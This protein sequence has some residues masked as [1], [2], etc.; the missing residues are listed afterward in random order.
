MTGGNAFYVTELLR[1][2]STS[3]SLT[4]QDAVL[5]RVDRLSSQDRALLEAV[6]IFPRHA[7]IVWAMVLSGLPNEA[8]IR[9]CVASGLLTTDGSHLAFRHEIARQAVET[10]LTPLLRKTLNTKLLALLQAAPAIPV[11]RLL[12]HARQCNDVAAIAAL[13]PAAGREAAAAGAHLQ[14]AEYFEVALS[15]TDTGDAEHLA[16]LLEDVALEHSEN[17]AFRL[18]IKRLEQA[19]ALRLT[20]NQQLRAGEVMQ[21]MSLLHSEAGQFTLAETVGDSAISLLSGTQS[22][23]LAMA[24]AARAKLA[25]NERD[26]ALADEL[27]QAAVALAR[28]VDRVDVLSHALNTLGMNHWGTDNGRGL[29]DQS[30]QLALEHRFPDHII[31]AYSNRATIEME[32]LRYPE[33]LMDFDQAIANAQKYERTYNLPWDRARRLELLLRMGR[34]DEAASGCAGLFPEMSDQTVTWAIARLVRA[35]L[36]TRR[37][38][39]DANSDIAGIVEYLTYD[40][41]WLH[42]NIFANLMAERAW[43]GLEDVQEA[44]KWMD[45]VRSISKTELQTQQTLTWQRLLEPERAI[46]IPDGTHPAYRLALEGNWRAAALAWQAIGDPYAQALALLEGD[47]EAVQQSLAILDQLGAI[48]VASHVRKRFRVDEAMSGSRG[49]RA[50]TR[51][52]PVGLTRRQMQVLELLNTGKS[53]A[54][55]AERLF[56]S[57]KTVDHHVSAI[58]AKLDVASRSEAA[59]MARNAGWLS[60]SS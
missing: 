33:A 36:A 6:S 23:E 14:A 15:F 55:I 41:S 35:S 51:A 3:R 7:E 12:H 42:A 37:G 22:A 26:V 53:N 32:I 16:G 47:A 38:S 17:N 9:D 18:A 13:A 8:N 1:G 20:L 48:A 29:I 28:R 31:R 40:K 39:P 59:A 19:L 30:L 24:Y 43:L 54:E 5:S 25:M 21:R 2:D 46:S 57:A 44:I 34:W 56:L 4:V 10:A 60:G 49:P 11:A 58:L 45:L 27:G 50:S 52:N